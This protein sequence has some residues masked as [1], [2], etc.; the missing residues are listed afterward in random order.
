MPEPEP[1]Q[2]LT[3]NESASLLGISRA[4]M[5]R[6]LADEG[7]RAAVVVSHLTPKGK[8]RIERQS[9]LRWAESRR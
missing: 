6:L 9:L 3:V 8:M 5:Y 4:T 7:F 2:Y 1:P